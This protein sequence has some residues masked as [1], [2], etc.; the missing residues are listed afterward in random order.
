M[1]NHLWT[2]KMNSAQKYF[3]ERNPVALDYL[4]KLL[5]KGE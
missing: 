3:K 2:L 4:P 5:A 1:D